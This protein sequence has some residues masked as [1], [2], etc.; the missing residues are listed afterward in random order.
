MSRQR[1]QTAPA[2]PIKAIKALIIEVRVK[3]VIMLVDVVE[4]VEVQDFEDLDSVVPVKPQTRPLTMTTAVIAMIVA[5]TLTPPP[6][7]DVAIMAEAVTKVGEVVNQKEDAV[8]TEVPQPPQ[9]QNKQVQTCLK[10]LETTI[11]IVIVIITAVVMK[12]TEVEIAE[13]VKMVTKMATRKLAKRKIHSTIRRLVSSRKRVK[14]SSRIQIASKW[15]Q[16]WPNV[17]SANGRSITKM[18]AAPLVFSAGA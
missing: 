3:A 4:V 11:T 7:P 2:P 10:N 6:A 17:E 15:R 9:V 13:I 8:V 16:N 1:V 12:E 5:K 18:L 14:V